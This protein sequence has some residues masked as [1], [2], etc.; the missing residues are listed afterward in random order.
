MHTQKSQ[1][2]GRRHSDTQLTRGRSQWQHADARESENA[3]GQHASQKPLPRRLRFELA[4]ALCA[5]CAHAP[6]RLRGG[7]R[8]R[9]RRLPL[10]PPG[11]DGVGRLRRLVVG[12]VAGGREEDELGPPLAG[13]RAARQGAGGGPPEGRRAPRVVC[14]VEQQRVAPAELQ[15]RLE[16][17]G[18]AGQGGG[19]RPED[20]REGGVPA[21]AR[22]GHGADL[23]D[24]R[25]RLLGRGVHLLEHLCDVGSVAHAVVQVS[26]NRSRHSRPW[27]AA[28]PAGQI[29]SPDGRRV[30]Q[31]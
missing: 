8:T 23:L 16:A 19:R 28:V 4:L 24:Q 15:Q 1:R 30:E 22:V 26:A 10:D 11:E 2:V 17:A 18:A 27:Q 12:A 14:A 13:A 9:E 31:A 21:L 29:G 20:G 3:S 6:K 25:L 5:R 7:V